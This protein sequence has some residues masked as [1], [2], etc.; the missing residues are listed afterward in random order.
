MGESQFEMRNNNHKNTVNFESDD[1][2]FHKI[3]Y[4]MLLQNKERIEIEFT[5]V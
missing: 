4:K 5:K 2:H 3:A 1:L